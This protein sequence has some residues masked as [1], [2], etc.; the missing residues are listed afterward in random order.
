[1]LQKEINDWAFETYLLTKENQFLI[2]IDWIMENDL[3]AWFL[4]F[5]QTE[6][7]WIVFYGMSYS[8][9]VK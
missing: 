3:W 8:N 4:N 1:M 9:S 7:V 6:D 2:A 5:Y